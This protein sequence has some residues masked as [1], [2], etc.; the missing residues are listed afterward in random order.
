MHDNP[1]H[2]SVRVSFPFGYLQHI[3]VICNTEF[4]PEVWLKPVVAEHPP[5]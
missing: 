2:G 1:F 5:Y 4:I 3:H